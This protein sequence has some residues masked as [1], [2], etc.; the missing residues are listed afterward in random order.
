M[1]KRM[2]EEQKE[3]VISAIL[4]AMLI[5]AAFGL[6]AGIFLGGIIF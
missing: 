6:L 3:R 2:N 5:G 1:K 4:A